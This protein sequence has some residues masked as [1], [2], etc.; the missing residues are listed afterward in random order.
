MYNYVKLVLKNDIVELKRV[1]NEQLKTKVN[2][3]MNERKVKIAKT[4]VKSK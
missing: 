2:Q 3:L 1:V 4:L